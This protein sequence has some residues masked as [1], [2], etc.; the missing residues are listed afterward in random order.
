MPRAG[1]EPAILS[2]GDFK[3]PV[4]T[5]ST[6]EAHAYCTNFYMEYNQYMK[7]GVLALQGSF[8]EHVQLIEK[9]GLHVTEVRTA[10]ALS[11]VTHLIIPGGESTTM[12]K[13]AEQF[14]LW[15]QLMKRVT[16]DSIQ[17]FGTCAGAILM[18]QLNMPFSVERNAYGAQTMSCVVSLKSN[19]SDLRGCFIR[20]PKITKI[21]PDV[22]V[23]ARHK[24]D[25]VC[26]RW[27]GHMA[28]TFHPELIHEMRLHE[29]F[30]GL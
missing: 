10:A 11:S 3:S 12:R 9:L 8:V 13:L 19:I 18:S 27:R 7:I 20:A 2:A 25:P 23:L 30:L 21:A 26:I 15:N 14:N 1:L 29:L 4:Y 22:Q 17:L 24:F 28:L 16:D 5:N 6:T